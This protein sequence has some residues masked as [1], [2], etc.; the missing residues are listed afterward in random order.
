MLCWIRKVLLYHDSFCA[1]VVKIDTLVAAEIGKYHNINII[2]LIEYSLYLVPV[3][4]TEAAIYVEIGNSE[5]S[6][7]LVLC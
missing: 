2:G 5:K 4:G 7:V 3:L 1:S 6:N